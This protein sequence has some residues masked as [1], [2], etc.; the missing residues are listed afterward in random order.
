MLKRLFKT[1]PLD[2]LILEGEAAKHKLK[3]A[4]GPIDVTLLGIGAIIG[5]RHPAIIDNRCRKGNVF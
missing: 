5:E 3:R 1:K 2:A 4:L